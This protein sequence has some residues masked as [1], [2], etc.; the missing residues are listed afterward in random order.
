[1]SPKGSFF[2]F[3][4]LANHNALVGDGMPRVKWW[5]W[6]CNIYISVEHLPRLAFLVPCH[7]PSSYTNHGRKY[8]RPQFIICKQRPQAAAT[9]RATRLLFVWSILAA[10]ANDTDQNEPSVSAIVYI[11]VPPDTHKHTY[12]HLL[13]IHT[14]CVIIAIQSIIFARV[15]NTRHGAH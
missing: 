2:Y 12:F 7:S 10:K 6:P 1:M 13:I 14:C 4:T 8:T 5:Q 11:I 3:S 9:A 15:I